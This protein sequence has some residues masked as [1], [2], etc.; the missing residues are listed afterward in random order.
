MRHSSIRLGSAFLYTQCYVGQ[1]CFSIGISDGHNASG[2][3]VLLQI[4]RRPVYEVDEVSLHFKPEDW[5][6]ARL[7]VA[8]RG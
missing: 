8:E 2:V 3:E 6:P 7:L 4:Y 5:L 1:F